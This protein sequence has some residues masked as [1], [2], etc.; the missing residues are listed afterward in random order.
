MDILTNAV[1]QWVSILFLLTIPI[2]VLMIARVAK[3]AAIDA[4]FD[5]QKSKLL[6]NLVLG[7]YAIYFVYVSLMSF[8]GIFSENTLPPK[9]LLY[10]L[11]PLLVFLVLVIAN[12]KVYKVILDHVTLQSLVKLHTFRFI[13][14]FF[15]IANAYHAL[16]TVFAYI[17]GLGDIA[18]AI[19]SI[20]VAKAIVEKKVYAKPL[21]IVWNIF[22]LCD[23]VSV[24]VTAIITTKLSITTGTQGLAE[25]ANFPFV[26]IPAFAPATI[27][28]LHLS[29]FRKLMQ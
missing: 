20:W 11:F 9:V 17:A 8:T 12:L 19:S 25:I 23:I 4:N 26:L 14:V 27:I 6:Y 3:R 13:G 5:L 24:L 2:P 29:I 28:F 15:L 18:T 7:F 16:P 1:P 10:T 21:T 22:G